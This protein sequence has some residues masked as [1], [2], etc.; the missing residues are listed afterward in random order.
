VDEEFEMDQSWDAV[1][2][3]VVVFVVVVVVVVVVPE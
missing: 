2:M 1:L 3:E